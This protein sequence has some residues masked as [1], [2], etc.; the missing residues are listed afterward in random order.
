MSTP[1]VSDYL[2]YANLQMA[3]E[4][5]L[6][7]ESGDDKGRVKADIKTAL[8]DG[9]GHASRFT[10]TEA[11]KF[12][13]PD[14]GW[15]VLDQRANTKTGFSGTLFKN[16]ETGDLVLSFRSTEFIDD[17]IRDSA[18]TNSLEVFDTGWAWGQMADMEAWHKELT[19]ENGALLG[20]PFSVTGY[21]LGGHL[22][23]AFNLLRQE[24][25]TQGQVPAT[26]DQVVT[27]NGAGVG[28]VK[29]GTLTEAL[30]NFQT[31]SGSAAALESRLVLTTPELVSFYRLLQAN[32][33]NGTWTATQAM[34]EL[35]TLGNRPDDTGQ[36]LPSG[37][38]AANDIHWK[39]AA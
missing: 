14:T 23:T 18:A 20:K 10:E 21:S 15:T 28:E 11:T 19:G 22:A 3:A 6:V 13:D 8:I 4:A 26:L 7:N 17:A 2:K 5:F 31:L 34:G 1:T 38:E 24:E 37:F 32:L 9:N 33:K 27:F 30:R 39:Q 35:T 25:G 29:S 36:S 12:V 16:N